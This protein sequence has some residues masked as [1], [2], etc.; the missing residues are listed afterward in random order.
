MC[1]TLSDKPDC[2]ASFDAVLS[3]A[4]KDKQTP[5]SASADELLL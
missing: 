2:S 1:P 3:F 5:D 4:E